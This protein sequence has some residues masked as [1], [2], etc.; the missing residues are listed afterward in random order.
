MTQQGVWPA[1]IPASGRTSDP[2]SEGPAS[3]GPVP[4][5][6]EPSTKAS[7]DDPSGSTSPEEASSAPVSATSDAAS[8]ALVVTS[9]P[10]VA[11]TAPGAMVKSDSNC[12]QAATA[13]A[14]ATTTAPTSARGFIRKPLRRVTTSARPVCRGSGLPVIGTGYCRRQC[15]R[16]HCPCSTATLGIAGSPAG[17]ERTDRLSTVPIGRSV[18]T[19]PWRRRSSTRSSPGCRRRRSFRSRRHTG[20]WTG[21][22]IVL[23]GYTRPSACHSCTP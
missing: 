7:A 6:T 3:M 19:S 4:P 15:K 11:S 9:S 17:M 8:G 12:G 16:R 1:S 14:H 13:S 21:S 18:R 23:R 20:K 2:A 5:S 22:P 10:V